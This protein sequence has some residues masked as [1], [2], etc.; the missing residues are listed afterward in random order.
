MDEKWRRLVF[1]LP[2]FFTRVQQKKPPF[3]LLMHDKRKTTPRRHFLWY[4]LFA[5][6]NIIFITTFSHTCTQFHTH[7]RDTCQLKI[8]WCNLILALRLFFSFKKIY[9][10]GTCGYCLGMKKKLMMINKIKNKDIYDTFIN[11]S[12]IIINTLSSPSFQYD[13]V[14]MMWGKNNKVDVKYLFDFF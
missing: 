14:L 11:L 5:C 13:S 8:D 4:I 3:R 10:T 6:I 7:I 2:L 12:E 1:W 9:I